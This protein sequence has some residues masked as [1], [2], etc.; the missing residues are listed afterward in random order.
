MKTVLVYPELS[1]QIVGVLFEV[2][3]EIGGAHYEK[4][5][6]KAIAN[7][8]AERGLAYRKEFSEPV[9]LNSKN[10]CYYRVDF[11]IENK[12]VLEIKRGKRFVPNNFNQLETYL[13]SHNVSLGILALFT[14]SEVK[15]IRVVNFMKK[16]IQDS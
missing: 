7:K 14:N 13:N 9:V 3:N 15:F 16:N 10:L 6:Q 1:Y 2:F 4:T 5:L 11:L 12:I 8:L